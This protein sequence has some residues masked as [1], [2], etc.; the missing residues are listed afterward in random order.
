MWQFYVAIFLSIAAIAVTV[1][2]LRPQTADTQSQMESYRPLATLLIFVIALLAPM[3]VT[4]FYK[5]AILLGLIISLAIDL[6]YLQAGT[7]LIVGVAAVLHVYLLNFL[8]FASQ[9]TLQ[10]PTLWALLLLVYAA[11]IARYLYP[12]LREQKIGVAIYTAIL[13]LMTWQ[14]LELWAQ[15]ATI[16]AILAVAGA[17][18]F[19]VA[20]TVRALATFRQ[21]L[22]YGE[23]IAITAYFL[24]EWLIALS[25]WSPTFATIGLA[26]AWGG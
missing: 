19:I 6:L 3:P 1:W 22:A 10:I 5:A 26:L 9:T 25:I 18:L 21:P 8:A 12:H 2:R 13:M 23:T 24:A 17:L 11:V 4:P 14:A 15:T 16:W 20:D 7:P